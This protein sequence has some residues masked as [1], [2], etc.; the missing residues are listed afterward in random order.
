MK[1]VRPVMHAKHQPPNAVGKCTG[2]MK[3]SRNDSREWKAD[4]QAVG[5]RERRRSFRKGKGRFVMFPVSELL[6]KIY[7]VITRLRISIIT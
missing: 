1:N 6:R 3:S 7:C 5:I 4:Q 2:R